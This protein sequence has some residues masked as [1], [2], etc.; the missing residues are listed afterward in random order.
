[1]LIKTD[2]RI[3][4]EQIWE[5]CITD[6]GPGIPKSERERV[7]EPFCQLDGSVTRIHGGAG[8]GL[9]IAHRT[10]LAHGGTLQ[11]L[12]GVEGGT[13]VVMRVPTTPDE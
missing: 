6:Q 7:L 4:R 10:C 11:I 1:M 9:A 12:E 5:L 2:Y 13:R 3:I 8:L